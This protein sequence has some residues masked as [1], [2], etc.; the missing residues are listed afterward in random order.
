MTISNSPARK[1]AVR[2]GIFLMVFAI[3]ATALTIEGGSALLVYAAYKAG[4]VDR[5][6]TTPSLPRRTVK[7]PRAIP[8][9][10]RDMSFGFRLNPSRNDQKEMGFRVNSFGYVSN[11]SDSDT[12]SFTKASRTHRIL[13]YGG[14]TV[15]GVGASANE[16]TIAAQLESIL[17]ERYR[18]AQLK[19]YEVI[20]AGIGGFYS[21]QE[22]LYFTLEGLHYKP[23][24]VVV[25]DGLNDF[26]RI[27][28]E[29]LKAVENNPYTKELPAALK[30]RF[31]PYQLPSSTERFTSFPLSRFV[32]PLFPNTF[33]LLR[34]VRLS[35]SSL[36]PI[37]VNEPLT[38]S[39]GIALY[40]DNLKS[41]IGV[42]QKHDINVL[43]ALQPTLGFR[44]QASPEE[45]ALWKGLDT[46]LE[47]Q[48]KNYWTLARAAFER[49][50]TE[51]HKKGTKIAD[52]T[53]LFES[54]LETLYTDTEHYNDLG[55]RLIA[56]Q[57]AKLLASS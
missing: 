2:L 10:Q 22:L 32:L 44:K 16:K 46:D 23:D 31:H 27:H 35:Q 53:G 13:I 36:L 40:R 57:L 47:I 29:W 20:N 7:D 50:K 9:G 30:Y 18:P 17:N 24:T 39:L 14:S 37:H 54:N 25:L 8:F 4:R 42:A 38:P 51:E 45:Q 41:F 1:S 21:T 12:F 28:G 48:K 52:L 33:R 26:H 49:L 6:P 34:R 55:Q 56:E 11:T 19:R 5:P 43:I 15:Q 3:L